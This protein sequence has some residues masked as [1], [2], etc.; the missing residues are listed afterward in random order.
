[1]R[2]RQGNKAQIGPQSHP[3]YLAK[4]VDAIGPEVTSMTIRGTISMGT[5]GLGITTTLL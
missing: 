5:L 2:V 1:M 3:E 4:R